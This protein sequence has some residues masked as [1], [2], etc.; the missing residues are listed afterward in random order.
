MPS[1]RRLTRSA[2]GWLAA[3]L[4]GLVVPP[5]LAATFTVTT[6]DDAGAGSLRQALL[7]ANASPGPH[8][9]VVQPGLTGTVELASSLPTVR[10]AVDL[11]G[12]GPEAFVVDANR[13]GRILVFDAG[14]MSTSSISGLTLTGGESQ[15]RAGL[16]LIT[17]SLTL[18]DI[19]LLDN[20]TT[21]L[22]GG[23]LGVEGG[24]SLVLRRAVVAHN[25]AASNGGG[26]F[27]RG[28]LT[29]EQSAFYGNR[30]TLDGGGLWLDGQASLFETTISG[31]RSLSR[32]GAI[33]FFSQTQQV[34]LFQVS[35]A[36]NRADD[37]FSLV[38]P[39]TVPINL[40]GVV[41]TNT[42]TGPGGSI[43]QCNRPLGVVDQHNAADDDSCGFTGA[44]D[45]QGVD[46]R[47]LPLLD[48]GGPTPSVVPRP[49]S[50]LVDA[51][52]ELFC[53]NV[54]QRGFARPIDGD[55]EP[56]AVCDIGATEYTPGVDDQLVVF[57]DGFEAGGTSAWASFP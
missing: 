3:A 11:V 8:D 52:D 17:G 32:G 26:I 49:D 24:A 38:V 7:D 10:E 6:L 16:W 35:I 2:L 27:S 31:N 20:R 28:T 42:L 22:A 15:S 53:V 30:S 56:G 18:E 5:A 46:L 47:L 54:D 25:V 34:T 55:A 50:P 13:S 39:S 40:G 51:G 21:Q 4:L 1:D 23:A 12:P 33:A 29:V 57:E 37:G 48:A 14:E 9:I 43:G 36:D 19:H 41:I 45:L 44:S